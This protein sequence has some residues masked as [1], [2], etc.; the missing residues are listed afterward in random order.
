MPRPARAG[1]GVDDNYSTQSQLGAQRDALLQLQ[2]APQPQLGPQAHCA[3]WGW[4][5]QDGA[6]LSLRSLFMGFSGGW[7]D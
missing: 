3:A 1:L 6:V 5:L 4:Q 7:F 2:E